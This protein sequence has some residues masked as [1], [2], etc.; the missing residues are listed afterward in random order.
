MLW[1]LLAIWLGGW[2]FSSLAYYVWEDWEPDEEDAW[3]W[4]VCSFI[5]VIPVIVGMSFLLIK[6]ISFLRKRWVK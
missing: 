4:V 1:I 5:P 3:D 6:L 2:L